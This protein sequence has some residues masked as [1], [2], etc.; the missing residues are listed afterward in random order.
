MIVFCI[1]YQPIYGINK[2]GLILFIFSIKV[3]G[4]MESSINQSFK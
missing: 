3:K 4:T 1:H 2:Y